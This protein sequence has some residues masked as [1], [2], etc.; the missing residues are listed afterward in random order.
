ML[1][2]IKSYYFIKLIYT[3]VDEAQKLKLVKY[4]KNMQKNLDINMI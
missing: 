1:Q 2:N 4:N 3:F